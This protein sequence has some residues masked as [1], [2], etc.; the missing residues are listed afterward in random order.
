MTVSP[1][2]AV[3]GQR[4]RYVFVFL[5]GL[6]AGVIALVLAL[7]ALDAGKTW[8]DRYPL[9]LMQLMAA[10]SAQLRQQFEGNRCRPADTLAHL[11]ALRMLGNDLEPSHADL[12]SDRRFSAHAREFRAELERRLAAPPQDCAQLDEARTGIG[13]ACK[14]CHQDFRN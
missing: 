9:A 13:S 10:H 3:P 7:R 8:Q 6:G 2:P 4:G 11:E 5:L 1:P 12:G 14:A